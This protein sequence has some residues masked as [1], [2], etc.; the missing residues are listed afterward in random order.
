MIYRLFTYDKKNGRIIPLNLNSFPIFPD[1][2]AF[3]REHHNWFSLCVK[4]PLQAIHGHLLHRPLI[5]APVMKVA[6]RAHLLPEF[7]L[8]HVERP[9]LFV[10]IV[11]QFE[12]LS[13]RNPGDCILFRKT[14][15]LVQPLAAFAGVARSADPD[16]VVGN[17]RAA[18]TPGEDVLGRK[19]AFLCPA[20]DALVR[21]LV[22]VEPFADRRRPDDLVVPELYKPVH[23]EGPGV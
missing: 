21:V 3:G 1:I 13:F 11:E 4:H 14:L 5:H 20:V 17:V 9:A 22:L 18:T 6:G 8:V 15:P 23:L 19:R 2:L 16:R 12:I 7:L 10:E